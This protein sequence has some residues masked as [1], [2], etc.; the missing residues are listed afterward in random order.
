MKHRAVSRLTQLRRLLRPRSTWEERSMADLQLS[1]HSRTLF[2]LGS[3]PSLATLSDEQYRHVANSGSMG[4][5]F[6][7][8]FPMLTTYHVMEDAKHPWFRNNLARTLE[9]YR[10]DLTSVVWFYSDR[11]AARCIHPRYTPHLFPDDPMVCRYELPAERIVLDEDRPFLASDFADGRW[12]YRGTMNVALHLGMALGYSD[13][14]LLGIDPDT[15][16]HFYD[17]WSAFQPYLAMR[18][19]VYGPLGERHPSDMPKTGQPRTAMEYLH[20]LDRFVLRPSGRRVMAGQR[21][22]AGLEDYKWPS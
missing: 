10:E 7:F 6:S 9:P 13:F 4:I 22:I 2:I 1:R 11:D 14:V 5:N 8:V 15:S 19:R 20:A 18:E 21:S 17:D 12:R 16:A 3:G